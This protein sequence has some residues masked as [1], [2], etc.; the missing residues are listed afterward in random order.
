MMIRLVK[1]QS[2]ANS[3]SVAAIDSDL[4]GNSGWF[5]LFSHSMSGKCGTAFSLHIIIPHQKL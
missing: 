3:A 1:A 5:W 4:T 2:A